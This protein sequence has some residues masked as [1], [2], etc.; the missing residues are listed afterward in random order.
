MRA[1]IYLSEEEQ[2]ELKQRKQTEKSI[3]IYRRYQYLELSN[4]GMT[5]LEIA[6]I[7]DVTNDTITDWRQL[8][9]NGGLEALSELHY[10]GRRESRIAP[11]KEQIKEYIAK[12]NIGTL[13]QLQG[14][15]EKTYEIGVSQSWLFRYCKK[16]SIF[17][18]KK[19]NLS[20]ENQ[21]PRNVKRQ[22]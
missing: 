5:N 6:E 20:M 14:Y 9:L 2:K 12:E 1:N 4:R 17:L 16:N 8:F 21:L 10:E 3:K 18:T 13:A 22:L 11:Y 19:L 7:L 15:L